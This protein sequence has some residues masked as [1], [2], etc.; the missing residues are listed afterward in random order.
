MK[1]FQNILW[2]DQKFPSVDNEGKMENVCGEGGTQCRPGRKEG[3]RTKT[4]GSTS[5]VFTV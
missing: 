5:P 2:R 3:R 4:D 1:E